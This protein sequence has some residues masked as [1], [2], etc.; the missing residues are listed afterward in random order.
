MLLAVGGW[1]SDAKR[2]AFAQIDPA[3]YE[4]AIQWRWSLVSGHG[5]TLY[6]VRRV[7]TPSEPVITLRMHRE[8]LGLPPSRY[9]EVDHRD[10]NGLNNRRENLRTATRTQN[11][12]NLRSANRNSRSGVRGV[13]LDARRG[14]YK[15]QARLDGKVCWLGYHDTI[16]AAEA[17][18]IAFRRQHYPFS[19]MDR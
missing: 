5:A 11:R 4:W 8:I 2:I 18:C 17:A 1:Q 3:D 19:E 16:E 7:Y 13:S 10:G 9:P 6:A 12:Q 15:A 14:K